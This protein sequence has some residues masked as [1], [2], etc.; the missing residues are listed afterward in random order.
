M[1]PATNIEGGDSEFWVVCT[2]RNC[3]TYIDT[4]IAMPH[5]Q[6]IHTDDHREIGVFGGYGSGKTMCTMKDDEKHMLTT[7]NGETVVGSKV[8]S[9]VEQTY[10]K[11]FRTDFP[12]AFIARKNEQKKMYVLVNGH[13]LLIKSYYDEGIMR[14]LNLSRAH[15]VEASEVDHEIFVQLQTRMR[16]QK[17][18]ILDTN[19]EGE[20]IYD[21]KTELFKEKVSWRKLIV[22]SNPSSGWIRDNYLLTSSKINGPDTEQYFVEEPAEQ[23]SSHIIPTALNRYLPKEFEEDIGRG[24]PEWWK[25]RYLKGSFDYAEG[26]VYPKAL[27]TFMNSFDIPESWPRIIACDY[28]IRDATHILFGAVDSKNNILYVYDEI[29]VTDK[30]YKQ[31]AKIYWEHYDA[32]VRKSPL[33]CQPVMDG[34]SINKRNDLDLKTIGELFADEGIFFKGAQMDLNLR[35]IKTNSFIEYAQLKIFKDKC[36]VLCKEL[37]NYKFPDRTADGRSKGDKPVDKAN[38]GISALE[39]MVVELPEDLKTV[40]SNYKGV[41]RNTLATKKTTA[42]AAFYTNKKQ[43][44]TNT[45]GFDDFGGMF[46]VL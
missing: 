42:Y 10:E 33:Y 1:K 30:V 31:T 29:C 34:K 41:Q 11:E 39:F 8:L 27:S 9:Q 19:E 45:P 16:N 37:M 4:Y 40:T 43:E 7:P 46:E 3:N 25:K 32:H 35:I 21:P 36:P 22:E 38:H 12:R 18:S 6:K 5:Q 28:G 44:P 14:S 13:V 2:K 23:R 17:A 15:I 26:A 24:K 20:L